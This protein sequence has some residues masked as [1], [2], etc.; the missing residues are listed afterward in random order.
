MDGNTPVVHTNLLD[1]SAGLSHFMFTIRGSRKNPPPPPI[2]VQHGAGFVGS[3]RGSRVEIT[4]QPEY[5]SPRSSYSPRS[6]ALAD[7]DRP[8]D[9]AFV[10]PSRG[11]VSGILVPSR[12][13]LALAHRPGPGWTLQ[14]I[15]STRLGLTE[16][17]LSYHIRAIE[18]HSALW[19]STMEITRA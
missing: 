12:L 15:E 13:S 14:F 5:R 8:A 11:R 1:Q 10:P 4:A 18:S 2:A 19:G 17:H 7:T 16:G 9:N 3:L 6:T